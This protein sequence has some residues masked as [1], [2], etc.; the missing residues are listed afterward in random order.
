MQKKRKKIVEKAAHNSERYVNLSKCALQKYAMRKRRKRA[1]M[2]NIFKINNN[3][4]KS[5]IK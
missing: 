4:T 3:L 2:K 5:F 1:V